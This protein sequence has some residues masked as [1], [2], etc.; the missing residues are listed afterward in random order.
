MRKMK[1]ITLILFGCVV[2]AGCTAPQQATLSSVAK[3]TSML[4]VQGGVHEEPILQANE[5]VTPYTLFDKAIRID[6]VDANFPDFYVLFSPDNKFAHLYFD[7]GKKHETLQRRLL[8]K[9]GYVWN[10]EDDDT[11]N[12]RSKNGV[13][14]IEKR[15]KLIASQSK[16]DADAS[17]G[18]WEEE[19]YEGMLP[20]ASCP[21]IRYR[22][23]VR[24]RSHGGDGYYH[25]AMTYLEAENGKDV[26]YESLGRLVTQC[27]TPDDKDAI[28]WQL[29]GDDG[30]VEANFLYVP[31]NQTLTMLQKNFMKIE[32]SLNYT[33]KRMTKR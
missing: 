9:G 30:N 18:S 22:L 6:S 4:I 26:V 20:A 27:G 31:M 16:F 17:L 8:P 19:C 14:I 11:K 13:W 7:D 29:I 25:L 10:V 33:L 5:A 2:L 23:T 21:S 32:S 24:H 12:L 1:S 3:P 15:M 28:V